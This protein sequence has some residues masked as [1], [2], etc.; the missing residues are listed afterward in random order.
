MIDRAPGF[1]RRNVAAP[2]GARRPATKR[3]P[4]A[5][6]RP[7]SLVDLTKGCARLRAIPILLVALARGREPT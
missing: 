1:T 3:R 7:T 5:F 6:C 2:G 4:V